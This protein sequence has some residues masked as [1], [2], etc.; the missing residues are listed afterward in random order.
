MYARDRERRMVMK[1][2]VKP[3]LHYES[4]ELAQ[5]IAGCSLTPISSV[6][7][8]N[9]KYSGV[10][11]GEPSESWFIAKPVCDVPVEDYCYTNSNSTI[12]TINS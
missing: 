6:D 8:M 11:G 2:Y 10:I 12:T 9:C 4:F 5:H 1:P 7:P 3:E